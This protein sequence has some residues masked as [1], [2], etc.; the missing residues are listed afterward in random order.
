[1]ARY[2]LRT[3]GGLALVRTDPPS[4]AEALA[5]S[6]ALLILAYLATR[7]AHTARRAEVAELLWPESDRSRAL[8]ALRQALFFLSG[9]A[10]EVLQRTDDV[11]ALDPELLEVDLWA[12]ERAAAAEEHGAVIEV[13]QGPFAAGLEHKVGSEAEHWIEGVNA[14][15][16]VALE[17]AYVREVARASSE[18]DG[19][20]AV[21]LA[22]AFAA[23]NP[24]DEQ[25]QRLLART[26]VQAGDR[27]GALQ[28]LEEFRQLSLNA[29][30]EAPSPELEARLEAIRAELLQGDGPAAPVPTAPAQAAPAALPRR[31]GP[32]F[33]VRGRP[34]SRTAVAAAGGVLLL[35]LLASLLVPR[36]SRSAASPLADLDA[37]VLAV[38]R[39]GNQAR[40]VELTLRDQ[41]VSAAD[42][43]DLRETDLPAPDGRVVATTVQ[44]PDGWNLAVR[45]GTGAP[46]VLTGAPGDEYPVEWSPD[47]RYLVY[48]HRRILADGRTQSYALAVHDLAA[49]TSWRLSS[50]ES[51]DTPSAD[52]SPD[53]TR[54]AFTA[55]VRGAPDVFLVDFNGANLR[56]LTRHPAWDGEPAWS[57]N[58]ER[59]AFVSRRARNTDLYSVRPEGGDLQRLTQT[60]EDERCPIW[61]SPGAVAALVGGEDEGT[62][63]V[64]DTY[65]GQR[66]AP[67]GP[68]DLVTLL[69]PRGRLPPWLDRLS[70]VPRV[71]RGSPGQV[72]TLQVEATGSNG[73]P[74]SGSPPVEWS[75][76]DPAVAGLVAPGRVRIT[77]AG[78]TAVIATAAGWRAD[79]LT[80]FAVPLA[81]RP[82]APVFVETWGQGLQGDRWRP[83]GDP[84]PV[85]R[86]AGGP[87]DAGVFGNN[88]DA[89]F[90]SG[91]VTAQAFPLKDGLGVEVDARMRFTGKLH[92]EFGLALYSEPPP[93]SILASGT[94]PALVE[95]RIRGPSGTSG[96]EAWIATPERREALP[97][98]PDPGV[99][100]RYALQVL[101]D[102]G[103]ELVVDGRMLWRAA[104]PL[105]HR[106]SA[107]HVGLGFQ[108]FE[109]EILH[110]RVRVFTPPRYYL[111]EV[112]LEDVPA[113]PAAG[114]L[115]PPD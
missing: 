99:W 3:L 36:G 115:K 45:E 22:R 105:A 87:E 73:Q 76:T 71:S 66:H 86:P 20:R 78:Q 114:P 27:L 75:V 55:D 10:D 11:L 100:H 64:L 40:V 12:L 109:T 92:Q 77:A 29:M 82:A 7:P 50:L 90:A 44:A 113:A 88:G 4:D 95:L 48:A 24:L 96:A 52:W 106:A 33:T 2:R 67:G 34:V 98:P 39:Q 79:T 37:Q 59:I 6:K 14:R 94:A 56:D 81:E 70:I 21:R 5:N 69:A 107:V 72:L 68:P 83:F 42:R 89:F 60:G 16:A 93:D 97:P 108:S 15:I 80:L 85:T 41:G 8:R 18:G 38:A 84:A 32:V 31:S 28:A 101:A 91:A 43:A 102:G 112:T 51:A 13:Y 54:I 46:R 23:L 58:G 1:M 49:D 74:L 110:G 57:P 25:R 103:I 63:V 104:T 62:L 65:T 9:H 17:V 61:V 30:D 19:A 47:G 35:A 111:P 26:L 53:G